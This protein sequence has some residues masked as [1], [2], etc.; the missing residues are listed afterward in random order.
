[1][2][3]NISNNQVNGVGLEAIGGGT[4]GNEKGSEGY[5]VRNGGSANLSNPGNIVQ[6][7]LVTR[8]N[9]NGGN[10]NNGYDR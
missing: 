3:V 7:L 10:G 4:L 8:N 1:M 2:T 9:G 5:E 6:I